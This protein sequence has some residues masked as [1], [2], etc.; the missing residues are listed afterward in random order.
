MSRRKK[1]FLTILACLAG[2]ILI[3]IVS[4]VIVLQAGWFRNYVKEKIIAV[5]E[6][7][8][9]GKVDLGSF[10][11]DWKHLRASINDFVIHGTEPAGAPPLF[12]A[13]SIVLE[14]K[15]FSGL[16]KAIDLNYLGV[17]DTSVNLIVFPDGK[18]NI[19][20]PK[21]AQKPS[22]KSGLETV[23]DLAVN[24]FKI[25][26]GYIQ[27]AQQKTSFSAQGHNLRTQLFYNAVTPGYRGSLSI[28]PLVL[29][30]NGKPPL[31]AN[32]NLPV[33]IG[34]DSVQLANAKITTPQSNVSMDGTLEHMSDPR[35]SA[36]VTAHI[37]LSEV[38]QVAAID[39][40]PNAKGAPSVAD[41]DIA[42]HSDDQSIN[43]QNAKVTLGSSTI[44][45]SGPLKGGPAGSSL[46]F[47]VKLI[48]AELSKVL[49]L[50]SHPA[51]EV[52]LAGNAT[53]PSS[54]DYHV[55]G[56]LAARNISV[57]QGETS[58]RDIN[59]NSQVEA[60]PHQV[61]L[62]KMR[63]AAV[64]GEVTGN[65]RV[66]EF[67]RL[68]LDAQ[69]R[70]FDLQR[71][72]RDLTRKQLGYAGVLS[73]P[74][75]VHDD[76]KAK[77]T[78]GITAETHLS[79]TPGTKGVPVASKLNANYNGAQ[80]TVAVGKS[81]IALPHTRL[82]LT[83]TLGKQ[84]DLQLLSRNLNDFLPAA[85]FASSGKPPTELPITLQNG[86]AALNASVT[87]NLSA[88]QLSG[89]AALTRF[90]AEQRSFD[91]LAADFAASESGATIKNGILSRNSLQAR[92]GASV[93]LKKWS[94]T[95]HSPLSA[96]LTMQNADVA[97]VVALAGQKPDTAT[98]KL[99][100]DAQ[101]TGTVGN[102]QG[103]A[104]LSVAN[105]TIYGEPFDSLN[106]N[107]NLADRVAELRR[108]EFV[109][110]PSHLNLHARFVHPRD[111]FT[112]G[113]VQADLSSNEWALARLKTIQDRHPGLAGAV[114]LNATTEA[115]VQSVAGHSSIAVRSVN[116][117]L[118]ARNLRD[119]RQ[120]FGDLT[121]DAHTTGNVVNYN[122]AS[123]FTGS[124]IQ[125]S[126]HT[127]LTPE[128]PTTANVSVA[129]LQLEK[130]L[131]VAGREDVPVRGNA[132][133][134]AH[135]EGTLNQPQANVQLTL[136]NA[137]LYDEPINRINAKL[138]YTNQL[139]DL[140]SLQIKSP[141]GQIV[142]SA[143]FAHPANNFDTGE[144]RARINGSDLQL[145]RVQ[146]LQKR[147]PGL[148]GVVHI[149][150]DAAAN[151][152]KQVGTSK[153]LLTKLDS[154]I[155]AAGVTMNNQSFGD[156]RLVSQTRGT[157]LTFR[158]N[159]DFAQSAI[160]GQGNVQLA[161]AYPARADLTFNNVRY[162]NLRPFLSS[163]LSAQPS[164][165]SEV[166]G[167]VSVDGPIE[168]PEALKAQ[169]SLSKLALSAPPRGMPSS[170]G[171][172][173]TIQNEGPV[174]VDLNRSVVA[175][176]SAHLTGRSTDINFAGTAAL[177]G[178][179]ALDL[180]V[181][182][183]TDLGLLQDLDRDVYSE[184]NIVLT[185]AVRGHMS[186]PLVNGRVELN[187]ASINLTQSPNGISNANGVILLNGTSATIQNLTGESGGGKITLAGFG[188]LTGTTLRYGLRAKADHVRTRQSGASIVS[189][190]TLAL[191]GTTEH[192]VLSGDVVLEKLGFNSQSDFGSILSSG[193]TPP[194]TPS[195]PSGPI[196]GMRLD[197]H[198]RTA[199]DVRFQTAI[200]QSLQGI[201]DLN[202]LG[203]MA[204]PG[205]T[206]RVNITEGQLVFF[207]N[208]Y[209]VNR[210]TISFYNPLKIAPVLDVDLETTVKGVDVILGVAGPIE[211]MKLSYRSDPPLRFDE[212]VSLLATGKVPTSDPTIAA[213]NEPPPQQS[214]TQMGESAIVSQAVAAPLA[215]RLQRVFGVNQI[216]IDPTF[217]NGSALPQA[218]ITLQQQISGNI[219]FTYTTDLTQTNSQILRVEWAVSPRLSAVATRDENGL[220]GVDF[221]IKRQFR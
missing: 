29:S 191:N 27:F 99:A 159:S 33:A 154:D 78:T 14:L 79:I 84:I 143:S 103:T 46:Q 90:S 198:V 126:G 183:K 108:A 194:V 81:F 164:F 19:P 49:N 200:A 38:N 87:G 3:L 186:K 156:L 82:D 211:N 36:H 105:G 35:V 220:F 129:N 86:T 197:I 62:A 45:A 32:V 47:D 177:T 199:P 212:I 219:T 172:T 160:Q 168:Q 171:R 149:T 214:M 150:A 136:V 31:N 184:G 53:M 61:Q 190:A 97:D 41:A 175:V 215:N 166:D 60:D 115:D 73:G 20:T 170:T 104:N 161:G 146:N 63:L 23:V 116:G 125:G 119:K 157:D 69:L 169:L 139:V 185:A 144:V 107:A 95:P 12:R 147:Q 58:L 102:P 178:T 11:F 210:G 218:R 7:S 163:D 10:A 39:L 28:S 148:S 132:G 162:V 196:A 130:V 124:N 208:Q 213:H 64:G 34:K 155:G 71:I 133:M 122:L 193:A 5:T 89:N 189:S 80:D 17:K 135:L 180:R 13:H 179:Q 75:V 153:V 192:S 88:P 141:A 188:G 137:N 96:T 15:L 121:A 151:M 54:S 109:D 48:V 176:R 40:Y 165:D 30:A 204:N 56:T 37:A 4:A 21:V 26:N 216:K 195:A 120:S 101:I 59:F 158:L 83:G 42:I 181:D 66:Q 138:N 85:A 9:G 43:V 93:G 173:V 100:A 1:I 114:Q 209:T 205:L 25:E 118:A 127:Q 217:V 182:A 174:V 106:V 16:K 91:R 55:N 140:P 18:T 142:L 203:T 2:L 76:L 52:E 98:G 92:F 113:H 134:Q 111:S 67:E 8:T 94:S 77:G 50:S 72:T 65:L 201:A 22:N 70:N 68:T 117:N 145:A 110:G 167:K 128:Y 123:N 6:E 112:T 187:K 131:Q 24:Q 44:T 51:G 152:R 207:G 74:V 221:Y 206:G 202:V 57:Q